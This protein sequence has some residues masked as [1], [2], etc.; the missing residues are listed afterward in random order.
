LIRIEKIN[1]GQ[2]IVNYIGHGSVEVWRG[3]ALTPADAAELINS[4]RLSLFVTM[5]RLNAYFQDV[6]TNSLA[7]ALMKAENGGAVA[8]WVSSGA[9]E[10]DGQSL[11]S[12]QLYRLL[13][14]GGQAITIGEAAAKAKTAVGS[15]DIRRSWV[16]FGD[17]ATR[18]E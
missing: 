6:G 2:K 9:S 8:V 4:D 10:P 7:E 12:Q 11:M 14:G 3:S 17:P 16:L 15:R 18:L 13:F 5:T 1:E